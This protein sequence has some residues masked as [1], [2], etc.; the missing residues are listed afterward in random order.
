MPIWIDIILDFMK[1]GIPPLMVYLAVQ[2]VL[3]E[4]LQNQYQT[5]L[6]KFQAENRRTSLPIRFQA[7][8]RLALFSDRIALPNLIFRLQDQDFTAREL[9]DSMIL[10]IQQEFEHNVSQQVYVSAELWQ[11]ILKA[12]DTNVKLVNEAYSNMPPDAPQHMLAGM[13]LEFTDKQGET[14]S[15]KALQAIRQEMGILY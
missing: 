10:A 8:E 4:F 5:Q 13:L 11:I 12:R 3:R 7:Y 6:L 2:Y 1:V 14:P 9:R 15:D